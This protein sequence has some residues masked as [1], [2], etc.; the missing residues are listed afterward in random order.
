MYTSI[1]APDIAYALKICSHW[2]SY[3]IK[4]LKNMINISLES[5]CCHFH[6]M[7]GRSLGP[8]TDKKCADR[9]KYNDR[10]RDMAGNGDKRGRKKI[11]PKERLIV[12][13]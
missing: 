4:Y 13:I 6:T 12:V 2:A 7:L 10:R 1:C 9:I 3:S 11:Q 8:H 5:L